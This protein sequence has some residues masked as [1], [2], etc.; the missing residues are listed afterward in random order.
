M[1]APD[2][3]DNGKGSLGKR[4]RREKYLQSMHREGQRCVRREQ[5]ARELDRHQS[6]C[7]QNIGKCIQWHKATAERVKMDKW[8]RCEDACSIIGCTPDTCFL[9]HYM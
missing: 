8:D 3:A 9:T 5:G 7:R 1:T 4:E 2:L 6:E